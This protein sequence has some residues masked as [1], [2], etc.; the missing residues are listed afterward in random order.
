MSLVTNLLSYFSKKESSKA[1]EG[2][3][4]NCW[5]RQEL[6][7]KF[8]SIAKDRQININNHD[9]T[10]TKAFVQQFVD[11]HVDGIKLISKGGHSRCAVCSA[12]N[13]PA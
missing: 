8:R 6:D 12:G 13:A 11:Q 1:P 2:V 5:G 7:G 10:A 9:S 4:P 3:C